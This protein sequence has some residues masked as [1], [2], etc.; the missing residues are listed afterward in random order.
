MTQ[1]FLKAYSE[2]LIQTCHRRGAHAMGGM[3][4]QIPIN[5]DAAANEQAMARVRAD[6]LREV[7]AGHDGTWV[8]HPALIAVAMAIFDEHMPTPNQHSV[9]RQ[10]ATWKSA[11]VTWPHGWM[12][13]AACRSIT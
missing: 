1:P 11:C 9:L 5:N 3:A 4:A 12:A 10:D 8:A 13:T 2:L 6:K 7:T